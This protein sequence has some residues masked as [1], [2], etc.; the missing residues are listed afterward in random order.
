MMSPKITGLRSEPEGPKWRRSPAY[1]KSNFMN[2]WVVGGREVW[3]GLPSQE[4][5]RDSVE[6]SVQVCHS[7]TAN[8]LRDVSTSPTLRKL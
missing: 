3:T 8:D 7:R 6:E 5:M 1:R 4:Y 2:Q